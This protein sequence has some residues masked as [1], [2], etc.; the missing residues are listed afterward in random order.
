MKILGI[1]IDKVD[2]QET[3]E[4]INR[5]VQEK[6]PRQIV[7]LN[8]EMMM[9]ALADK[10]FK[11]VLNRTDLNVPDGIG[12][13]WASKILKN[14]LKER[15]TGTDLVW[16]IAELTNQ[17]GYSIYFLGAGEGIAQKAAFKLKEKY[18]KLKIAGVKASSLYDLNNIER[19]KKAKPDILLVAFGHPKQEKWLFKY[20]ERLGVPVSIGVGGAFDFISEKIPRAPL[21]VQKMGLEWL[22]RLIKEPWR[23]K[24]QLSLPKFAW[25]V[26]L[27]YFSLFCY[28]KTKE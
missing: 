6:K 14:P 5:F 18:P 8:P 13:V 4:I 22:Y 15:V 23:I 25:L 21:W 27:D 1:K 9:T 2:C 10:E 16:K 24:R 26:F 20:R 19:I 12:I 28:P 3:I 7:T 11:S 17:R